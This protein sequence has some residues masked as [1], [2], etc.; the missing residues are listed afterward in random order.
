VF[1]F[2]KRNKFTDGLAAQN[3]AKPTLGVWGLAPK[4]STIA[5]LF[6]FKKKKQK[7]LFCYAE[8][9]VIQTSAMPTQV[10]GGLPQEN[11][12]TSRFVRLSV[13]K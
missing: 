3:S 12:K 1:F 5:V 4:K 10:F 9:L 7:A 8:G 2:Q 6:F 13:Q 11:N